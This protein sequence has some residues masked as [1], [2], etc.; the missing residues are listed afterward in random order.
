MGKILIVAYSYTGN[1]YRIARGI[2]TLTEGDLYDIYP[3]QPYPMT[4]E[5][6]L[7]Q[8]KR[9]IRAKYRPGLLPLTVSPRGYDIVCAGSPNWCGTIA[10]PLYSWLCRNDLSGKVIL[11][12]CSHCG[13]EPGDMQRDIRKL[14][15]R[16]DVREALQVL[17]DGGGG[18]KERIRE[19][20]EGNNIEWNGSAMAQA[21]LLPEQRKKEAD[22]DEIYKAG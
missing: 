21:E 18:L 6:L 16:S 17:N 5:E 13:G 19:W 8:V 22:K 14:C 7:E 11:P 3:S 9:E 4:Y 15:S 20:L 10:P 2:Q 1:T 12:F